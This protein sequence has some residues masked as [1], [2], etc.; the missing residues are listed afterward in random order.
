MTKTCV[1]AQPTF[2][3]WLGWFDL[4]DQSDVTILL[5]DVQFSKQSWQQRNRVRTPNG[6]EFLSVPVITAGRLGQRIDECELANQHFVGKML[7]SLRANYAKS[8]YF[9]EAIEGFSATMETAASLG[10]LAALNCALISWMATRLGVTAPMIR[11]TTLGVG[12]S[13]G[14]HVAALCESVGADRYL[15]P[16]GAETY[17]TEDRTAFDERGISVWLHVYDHPEYAQR[18]TPFVP[19]ASAI[20][21]IFNVGP[22]AP[23][24]MR[25]GRRPARRLGDETQNAVQDSHSENS[26][27]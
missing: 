15:S 21:L 18:F 4:A 5:D 23:T 12:G 25:S 2:L 22:S 11:A 16:A 14:E 7:K 27:T 19:Y 8:S 24:V 9:G 1:I 3:P 20:D 26:E 10:N 13:R 17:L 6:L